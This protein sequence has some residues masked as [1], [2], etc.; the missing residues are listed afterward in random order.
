[1][2]LALAGSEVFAL[3]S[4]ALVEIAPED[5]FPARVPSSPLPRGSAI[6]DAKSNALVF[7]AIR[8]G[9]DR[10]RLM[11]LVS[12]V[13]AQHGRGDRACDKHEDAVDAGDSPGGGA[14]G[15]GSERGGDSEV[16]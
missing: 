9:A 15:L 13:A 4:L 5:E 3:D 8:A 2:Q 11:S 7:V 10:R 16:A 1:V 14:E 6:I 12:R